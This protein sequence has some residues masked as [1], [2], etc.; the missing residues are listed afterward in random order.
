M[1]QLISHDPLSS[2]EFS[3]DAVLPEVKLLSLAAE[4]AF[5]IGLVGIKNFA[6]SSPVTVTIRH[7][8]DDWKTIPNDLVATFYSPAKTPSNIIDPT[9]SIYKFEFHL[10]D[11]FAPQID[12]NPSSTVQK[13]HIDLA[14]CLTVD[15]SLYWDNNDLKNYKVVFEYTKDPELVPSTSTATSPQLIPR[16]IIV[17]TTQSAPPSIKS[18]SGTTTRGIIPQAS[19]PQIP[20]TKFNVLPFL[21]TV[22]FVIST[23]LLYYCEDVPL[24]PVSVVG[25]IGLST[26]LFVITVTSFSYGSR[27]DVNLVLDG[28]ADERTPLLNGNLDSGG[29]GRS[30]RKSVGQGVYD[31]FAYNLFVP[32][33]I[34]YPDVETPWIVVYL[35]RFTQYSIILYGPIAVVVFFFALLNT[36][37]EE[38]QEISLEFK[39]AVPAFVFGMLFLIAI[40]VWVVW[41]LVS[42][43]WV[44]K[45]NWVGVAF[46]PGYAA[47]STTVILVCVSVFVAPMAG[48][49]PP[50]WTLRV[51]YGLMI[52]PL[53]LIATMVTALLAVQR[54]VG[55]VP[56]SGVEA[57]RICGVS[58][59]HWV[60]GKVVVIFLIGV[61]IGVWA[62]LI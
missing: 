12:K 8:I 28:T 17:A 24:K 38:E 41:V 42:M 33:V 21:L 25:A 4:N 49:E 7:S 36:V 53:F 55:G 51:L 58:S 15:N 9:H 30:V 43:P 39:L 16:T 61:G 35:R 2:P 19:T 46:P 40:P 54:K 6:S 3:P 26:L 31:F 59:V 47:V 44:K 57:P 56:Q 52:G 11:L 20:K 29:G 10:P 50:T 34:P 14:V 62:F 1:W 18:E 48:A 45:N 32:V 23:I 27:S 22:L 13:L 60:I 5:L 37:P